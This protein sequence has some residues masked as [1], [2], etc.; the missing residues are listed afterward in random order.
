MEH[1]EMSAVLVTDR[2]RLRPL[3]AEDAPAIAE[4]IG[5]W[6]VMR[7]LTA[8]PWPYGLA[9]A[10]WFI[11]DPVSDGAHAIMVGG[12]LAGVVHI[13]TK[14]ELGYWLARSFHGRGYMTEAAAAL[15]ARH[16]ARGGGP[17][18]SGY[19]IGNA[20]SCNVLT[21]V[22]FV[23]TEV[24]RRFARPLNADVDIQRMAL[25]A[26]DWAARNP[27]RIE[28]ARLVL[29][30]H[31]DAEAGVLSRIG[32]VPE[33]ARMLISVNAP[34]PEAEVLEWLANSRWR[35]VP[36][37]RMAICLPNG[38]LIGS[39][40]LGGEPLSTAYFLG[41][42]Y[43]G[44]GYAT[45][46]M[47]AFLGEAFARFGLEAVEAG[48]YED[49]LASMAVLRK[50]GFEPFG[51]ELGSSKARLEPAPIRLYRLDLASFKAEHS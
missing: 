38:T 3:R 17:L 39:L 15:V 48:A 18:W 31:V 11:G 1:S 2:L 22:G 33:V 4:G 36:G 29:R 25:T 14:G 32:G 19:L 21:K 24:V 12:Q 44:Q 8:P 46:A 16:F 50:L 6:E 9:D 23:N 5:D 35:G 7:W 49:N 37:F 28:T 34:W 13:S 10:E 41:R 43:W 27:L 51:S 45:E 42:E 30:P 26:E 20:A 40:G 47:R